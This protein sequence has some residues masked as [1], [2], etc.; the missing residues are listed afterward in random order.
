MSVCVCVYPSVM[1][2]GVCAA[3]SGRR[4]EDSFLECIV[5]FNHVNPG[6][7]IQVVR[8]GSN[9]FMYT[10]ISPVPLNTLKSLPMSAS[11][12]SGLKNS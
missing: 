4:A 10:A 1:C 11:S 2:V 8:L 12:A 9:T 7:K 6:Y 5:S 3:V